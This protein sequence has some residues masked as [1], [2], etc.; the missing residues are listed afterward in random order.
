MLAF[1][2]LY[3]LIGSPR[4]SPSPRPVT[5]LLVLFD[6]LG[7]HVSRAAGGLQRYNDKNIVDF[8]VQMRGRIHTR[9][10]NRNRGLAPG[11]NFKNPH[12]SASYI[13]TQSALPIYA[14]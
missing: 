12:S 7:S 9:I 13:T 5:P 14:L 2:F 10:D 1:K 3:G 4:A 6:V 11:D 8:I